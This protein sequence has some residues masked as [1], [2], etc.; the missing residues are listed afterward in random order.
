MK[1]I[2]SLILLLFTSLVFSQ[3]Y[4]VIQEM[5]KDVR[6]LSSDE[7]EGRFTG[8][9]GEKLAA[10]YIISKFIDNKLLPYGDKNSFLQKF[11]AKL[12]DNPHS[13]D[14]AKIISGN[15]IIGFCDN[16]S[17][18]TVVIGAHYDH[19]GYGHTGSLAEERNQIHN[20]AD[21][22][23][24]GVSIMLHLIPSLI[25]NKNYNYLFIAFSG[26]EVGLYGSSFFTKNP[27]IDLKNVRFM[28]NF[29]MVGR[30]NDKRTLLVN[31]VG[32]SSKWKEIIEISNLFDLDLRTTE[33]GFGASDHTS[34]YN[35]EIPVL[36]FFTGQHEDYHKPTD[37]FDKINY[38]GMRDIYLYV[39][40]IIKN[41]SKIKQFDY[42]ETVSESSETPRFKVTLGI[43]PD[44]L[45]D[46][47]GLRID[48]VSKGKTAWKS[49]ILKGDIIIKMGEIDVTDIMTYM[50]GLSKFSTGD[51]TTVQVIRNGQELIFNVVFD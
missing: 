6:Y 51:S 15:N 27:T 46:E 33:S 41:S 1:Q 49:G 30:L 17:L 37:D 35:Q 13:N 23:A 31:G 7:L 50:K 19:L 14:N 2:I 36:H 47:G 44:Y 38:E 8:T 32:T 4:D 5:I 48:G 12:R 43:M 16:N 45:S 26:E 39:I 20:G 18:Q 25:Q 28:L 40:E 29:D 34:F 22:N 11:D 24:S 42:Q 10:D 21:D 9:K 3:D